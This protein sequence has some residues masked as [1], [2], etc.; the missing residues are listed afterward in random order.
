MSITELLE[1]LP[2]FELEPYDY[3]IEL[4]RE[5]VC[6]TGTPRKHPHDNEKLL[7]VQNPFGVNTMFYEFAVT[8]ILHVE[9]VPSLGTEDGISIDMV[10]IWVRL[11][12]LGM[13]YRPFEV[14]R[15][16][17]YVHDS[18]TLWHTRS[19]RMS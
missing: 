18:A 17:K 4:E 10:K 13:E 11:G 15:P 19:D 12:S 7:L 8:D 14:G 6:F 3:S 5:A 1:S 9:K 2:M 16:S